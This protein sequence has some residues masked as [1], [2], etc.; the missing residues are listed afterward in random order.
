M[1]NSTEKWFQVSGTKVSSCQSVL[2][3]KSKWLTLLFLLLLA[4]CVRHGSDKAAMPSAVPEK[5]VTKTAAA[6][7]AMALPAAYSGTDPWEECEGLD[8]SDPVVQRISEMEPEEF[9]RR[10][11]ITFMIQNEDSGLRSAARRCMNGKVYA[12]LID[13]TNNCAD[14]LDFSAEANDAMKRICADPSLEGGILAPIITGPNNPYEWA[15][16]NG[17]PVLIGLRKEADA[18]GYDR[19]VWFEIPKPE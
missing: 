2:R 18:A 11:Q 9:R 3:A 17:E 10:V 15:C 19:S 4:G 5:R 6:P 13:V 7:A 14:K 8:E 1:R 16:Q 12:C